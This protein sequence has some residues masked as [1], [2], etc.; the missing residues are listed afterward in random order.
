MT[1]VI[2]FVATLLLAFLAP[3]SAQDQ[4]YDEEIRALLA[5]P[6]MQAA[7]E[8]IEALDSQSQ[9]VLIELTEIPAP[10]FLE[11]VRG[12]R[13]AEMMREAGVPRLQ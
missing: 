10:P 11:A 8:S 6:Q 12:R 2:L 3:A 9:E 13:Y 7:F 4:Q 5:R 1:A